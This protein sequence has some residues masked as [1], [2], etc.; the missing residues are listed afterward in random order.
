MGR[1]YADAL[2]GTLDEGLIV[3]L[4]VIFAILFMFARFLL[5]ITY[6]MLDPRIRK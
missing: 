4:T 5:D 3:A 1:L 2:L 6:I